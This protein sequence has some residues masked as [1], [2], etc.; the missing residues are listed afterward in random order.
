MSY[1]FIEFILPQPMEHKFIGLIPYQR[2][3]VNALMNDGV[4]H[5][6]SLASDYSKVWAVIEGENEAF[7]ESIIESLPLSSF[8]SY[9]IKKLAFHNNMQHFLPKISLN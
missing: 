6:Y 4:I 8:M 7:V 9:E 5:T 2:A 3:K 1:Y